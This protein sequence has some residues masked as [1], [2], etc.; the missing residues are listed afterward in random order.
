M[1]EQPTPCHDIVVIGAGFGGRCAAGALRAAGIDN[2]TVLD[3]DDEVVSQVFDD[4]TWTLRT[5][6][7]EEFVTRAVIADT[8]P[9]HTGAPGRTLPGLGGRLGRSIYLAV[10]AS[11]LFEHARISFDHETAAAA[12]RHQQGTNQAEA[13]ETYVGIAANGVPNYFAL[14]ALDTG[15]GDRMA[16]LV[17]EAQVRYIVRLLV[18]LNEREYT[19]VEPKAHVQAQFNREL[20]REPAGAGWT[21]GGRRGERST[22][23]QPYWRRLRRAN[24]GDFEFTRLT[25]RE[26]DEDYSGP[27]VLID[28]DGD[29][30]EVHVHL[31]AVYEPVENTVRWYGRVAPSPRLRALHVRNN[32]PIQL[33]IGANDPV[34]GVLVDADPWGGSRIHG[35]GAYPYPPVLDAELEQLFAAHK[36]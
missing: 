16:M 18:A 12:F 4:D 11:C 30:H 13:A 7:G 19:R 3:G 25:D 2:V 33:R 31:L 32:L 27:A 6:A 8:G 24:L 22:R 15:L 34:D 21:V 35:R 29:R 14:T 23:S 26:E 17:I 10:P 9:P 1:S 20:R 28:A 5:S 36:D